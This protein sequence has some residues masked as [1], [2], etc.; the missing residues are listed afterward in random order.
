MPPKLLLT[1]ASSIA[2]RSAGI[3]SAAAPA[4]APSAA[5]AAA[6]SAA[7]AAA[8]SAAPAR[9]TSVTRRSSVGSGRTGGRSRGG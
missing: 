8:P 6:P 4:P 3:R 5:P 9:S 2:A 1:P 7:P